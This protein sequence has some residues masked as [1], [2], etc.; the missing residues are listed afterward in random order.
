MNLEF[1]TEL[2][3][4]EL[5]DEDF[6]HLIDATAISYTGMQAHHIMGDFASGD[7]Q[8]W[9]ISKNSHKGI[10]VTK[11]LLHPAL[12]ELHILCMAGENLVSVFEEAFKDILTIAKKEE[13]SK[14]SCFIMRPAMQKLLINK[15]Q[16]EPTLTHCLREVEDE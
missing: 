4:G 7:L 10:I 8:I 9:R 15:L 5:S 11:V 6:K 1:L 12:K 13:C 14:V 2:K 16:F 3:I